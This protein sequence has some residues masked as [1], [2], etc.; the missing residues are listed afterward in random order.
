MP[1]AVLACQVYTVNYTT[2]NSVVEFKSCCFYEDCNKNP[3]D[4]F[5]DTVC[6]KMASCQSDKCNSDYASAKA[7]QRP[8]LPA[9]AT[10]VVFNTLASL[11][12][13]LAVRDNFVIVH[14]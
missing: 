5:K 3:C 12:V 9:T 13:A 11:V 4:D 6:S 2:L 14:V 10:R 1:D 8:T 7:A